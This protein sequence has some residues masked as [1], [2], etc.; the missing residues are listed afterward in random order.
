MSEGKEPT[1]WHFGPMT[2][3]IRKTTKPT[4]RQTQLDEQRGIHR[5]KANERLFD[6]M[7]KKLQQNG[8]NSLLQFAKA[9]AKKKGISVDRLARRQKDSLICWFCE[10]CPELLND[11][12]LTSVTNQQSAEPILLPTPKEPAFFQGLEQAEA[13]WE[14]DSIKE[15]A[16]F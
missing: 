6:Q 5:R 1:I 16:S 3:I 11:D 2:I 10:N 4:I 8:K 13:N 14:W 15:D 9:V 12:P 7:M